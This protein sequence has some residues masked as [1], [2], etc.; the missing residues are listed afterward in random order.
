MRLPEAAPAPYSNFSLAFRP[1]GVFR[2]S[3]REDVHRSGF[4]GGNHEVESC[5]GAQARAEGS[6]V[7]AQP[8]QG[9]ALRGGHRERSRSRSYRWSRHRSEVLS[10]QARCRWS[11]RVL[12]RSHLHRTS[13]R[14]H[15]RGGLAGSR[16]QG[17]VEGQP[18]ALRPGPVRGIA[19]PCRR[20]RERTRKA[21]LCA[22]CE[23]R[24]RSGL[25]RSLPVRG[26][27]CGARNVR[28]QH[29]PETR[30]RDGG[31]GRQALDDAQRAVVPVRAR[32]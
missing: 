26:R 19:A 28:A 3:G 1:R 6:R 21:P 16:R 17:V 25:F 18:Q 13:R 10:H 8:V 2:G 15:V 29:V 27:V 32:T 30:R 7:Q 22:G 9:E 31:R 11:S 23:R 5:L 14:R 4:L 24:R 20:A 12:H